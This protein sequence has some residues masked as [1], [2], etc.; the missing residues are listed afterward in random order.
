MRPYRVDGV[1][2][3]GPRVR[4]ERRHFDRTL[5]LDWNRAADMLNLNAHPSAPAY[6]PTCVQALWIAL[7]SRL[8]VPNMPRETDRH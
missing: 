5:P 6:S 3:D 2:D 4:G 7:A 1:L 8:V